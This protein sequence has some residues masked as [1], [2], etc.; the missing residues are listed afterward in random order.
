MLILPVCREA[1]LRDV[2]HALGAHLH[3]HPCTLGAHHRRVQRLV[4]V[5]LG[6]AYPVAQTVGLGRVDVRDAGIYLPALR[7]FGWEGQRLEDYA[8]GEEVVYLLEG[9]ALALHLVPDGVDALDARRN[10]VLKLIAVQHLA[11]GPYEALDILLALALRGVNLAAYLL[12]LLREA[13]LHAE[14]LQLALYGVE[15]KAVCQWHEEIYRLACNLYLL[16][17]GHGTQRAHVVQTVGNLDDDD[18]HIVREREQHLAEVLRLLRGVVLVDTRHLRQ[19][20]H[21]RGYLGC[22]D[23]RYVFDRILRI[24]NHIVQ[25]RRHHRLLA[26]AYLADTDYCHL[27]GVY[28]VWL[29]RAAAHT[30]MRLISQ[31]EGTLDKLPVVLPLAH[32]RLAALILQ[33][34]PLILNEYFILGCILHTSLFYICQSTTTPLAAVFGF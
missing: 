9:Y 1:A 27:N 25:Q 26:E 13:I 19:A 20:I 8:Y 29:T 11:Y 24:F 4:A 7:L 5:G 28:D 14:V 30:L 15:A 2:V 3:L 17:A 22:E 12:I 33:L 32:L 31:Q 21:H 16:V 6:Y 10:L 18:A 34:L 23:A